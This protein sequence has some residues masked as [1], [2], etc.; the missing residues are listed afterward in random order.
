M[1]NETI[2]KYLEDLFVNNTDLERIA[3]YVGRFNPIRVMRMES[4][5]TRHSAILAWLMNPGESHG[6]G[7]DFL[8]AFLAEALRSQDVRERPTAL[9]VA[10]S[11]L[12]DAEVRQEW[13]HVD[14]FVLS[15]QNG[16]AFIIENKFH[17]RQHSNQLQRY[18]EDVGGLYGHANG[19]RGALKVRGIFLTLEEED[20][21]DKRYVTIH[22][23]AI[24]G[25]LR[26]L[27][28]RRG[29]SLSQEVGTFLQ[30]Y[31]RVISEATGRDKAMDDMQEL[32]RK[33]Y[34]EHREALEF[35]I[36][37]GVTTGFMSAAKQVFGATETAAGLVAVDGQEFYLNSSNG[38]SQGFI[39]RTWR[40]ALKRQAVRWDG[41][42]K[43]ADGWPLGCWIRLIGGADGG[44]AKLTLYAEVG[45]LTD[46]PLR[47]RLVEAIAGSGR[48]A[49][50]AKRARL[51]TAVYSRF[52]RQDIAPIDDATDGEFIA[53][54]MKKLL[55]DSEGVFAKV[56][57]A[58][59]KADFAS[60]PQ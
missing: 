22:Y 46:A 47:L 40:E 19:S 16:W 55:K 39:P 15:R 9:D 21:K 26:D 49:H 4:M 5:E 31:L 56:G 1:E 53:S 42:E 34:L 43:Y 48:P 35:I 18:M 54:Q 13:R 10:E 33:L 58:L 27:I 20:P 12:R 41:S 38:D 3:A 60:T 17:S 8:R 59:D 57:A 28:E 37:H 14:I 50:F 11:D 30:H 52:F 29:G 25:L 24:A 51:S 32:A 6:L 23:D 45:P 44:G 36:A 7:D 2:E